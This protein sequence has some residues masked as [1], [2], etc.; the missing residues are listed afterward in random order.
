MMLHQVL[1]Q[2][3]AQTARRKSLVRIPLREHLLED[4]LD[5]LEVRLGLE[6]I[7]HPDYIPF[8][9]APR[10]PFRPVLVVF[11]PSG[12]DEAMSHQ[13]ASGHDGLHESPVDH[14]AD[15]QT[16]LG[17]GHRSRKGQDD[18]TLR[19]ASHVHE[20]IDSFTELASAEG[21]T[22]H[23]LGDIVEVLHLG[24]VERNNGL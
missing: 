13:C 5:V 20:G 22:R 18:G 17:D 16:H 15:D 3:Q 8:R 7:V 4:L 14:L 9:T 2:L 19:I 1:A 21:C 12:L 10:R 23:G 11:Q 24:E 6:R